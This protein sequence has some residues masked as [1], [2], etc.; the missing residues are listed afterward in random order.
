MRIERRAELRRGAGF[1]ETNWG[2]RVGVQSRLGRERPIRRR[3]SQAQEPGA[4]RLIT[5]I[6]TRKT[7]ER[8]T[9]HPLVKAR[10]R[11]IVRAIRP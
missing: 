10:T 3:R 1:R 9:Q 11:W 6:P 5:K 7:R 8:S 2:I 4:G